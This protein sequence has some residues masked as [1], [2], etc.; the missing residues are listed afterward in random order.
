MKK[1]VLALAL[2]VLLI[3]GLVFL[4][5]CGEKK[6]DKKE[7]TTAN[8]TETPTATQATEFQVQNL[9]PNA[10]IKEICAAPA[11]TDSYTPNLINGLEMAYGTQATIGLGANNGSTTWDFKVVDEEGTAIVFANVD[12]STIFANNGG[13]LAF[14]LNEDGMPTAVAQ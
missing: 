4:T 12:L 1:S 3:G 13:A 2:V 6:E 5:G 10:T 8:T 11:G 7:N 9:V 14:Q